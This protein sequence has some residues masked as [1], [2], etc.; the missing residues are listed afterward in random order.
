MHGEHAPFDRLAYLGLVFVGETEAKAREGAEKLLWYMSANKV[1]GY[2]SNPPGYHPPHIAAQIMKG[3]RGGSGVPLTATLDDQMARGN[4]F[5][6]TPDQVYEQIK[7]FWE[8]SGGF[9]NMLMMGQAGFVTDEETETSMKLYAKEVFPR[10][11]E[12]EAST[13]PAEAWEKSKAMEQRDN[14]PLDGF[15]LEFVR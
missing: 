12:L 9:G 5:A 14:V 10:L 6:G 3:A 2:W 13:T 8:Y 7:N 15:A 11:K 1:P 4:V